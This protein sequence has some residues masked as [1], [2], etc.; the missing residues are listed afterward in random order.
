MSLRDGGGGPGLGGDDLFDE[1]DSEGKFEALLVL[2]PK[3]I[4]FYIYITRFFPL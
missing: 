2:E 3:L 1:I 4:T